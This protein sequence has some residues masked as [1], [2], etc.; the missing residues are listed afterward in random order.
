MSLICF[1]VTYKIFLKGILKDA[2][3]E[4]SY[5]GEGSGKL[6]RFLAASPY[7]TDE[8]AADVFS[9]SLGIVLVSLELMCL[10]HSG[11][12]KALGH[13][14]RWNNAEEEESVGKRVPHWPVI[15]IGLFKLGIILFTVTLSQ[16]TVDPATLTICGCCIVLAL[17]VT[18][19]M[20]YFFIHHRKKIDQ[21]T[22]RLASLAARVSFPDIA[23]PVEA[24]SKN[25]VSNVVSVITTGNMN[26]S[27]H[28]SATAEAMEK[29]PVDE[30][31]LSTKSSSSAKNSK[32]EDDNTKNSKK[33]DDNTKTS[34]KKNVERRQSMD[35]S[36]DSSTFDGI[37]VADLNGIITQVND[38]AVNLFGMFTY[39]VRH[40]RSSS[41]FVVF[42]TTNTFPS[43]FLG[44]QAMPLNKK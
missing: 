26:A 16:W 34:G 29:V 38:T 40:F 20:N 21:V 13:L 4:A 41:A 18:R 31:N 10:T 1:G 42:L 8:V 6:K 39:F 24:G 36:G 17:S 12:R 35:L 23:D 7:I 32:K 19:V 33:E 22:E 37:V 44:M 5:G 14:I 3:K 11:V 30:S 28:K 27:N 25:I 2:E 9:A 43:D 15:I